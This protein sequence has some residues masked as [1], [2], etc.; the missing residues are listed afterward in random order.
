VKNVLVSGGTRGLGLAVARTLAT[1]HYHVIACGRRMSQ[2]LEALIN[3]QGLSGR[4][5]FAAVDLGETVGIHGFVRRI[6]EEHGELYGLVNN[7]AIGQE[8]ILATMHESEI[9]DLIRVNVTG[10]ILLTKYASRSMLIRR[11]GRIVNIAS[12]VGHTGFNGLS[13][14]A[15]T[16]G[17]LLGFT[18]SLAR[19]LGKA[20]VTVNSVSPGFLETEMTESVGDKNL[21][22]IRRRSPLG[23][24]AQVNDVAATVA[25]LLSESAGSMTGTDLVVDAG[26]IA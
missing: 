8:G 5:S 26:S 2:G 14:Y 24:L 12:V 18:K 11:S 7:A 15:A 21:D 6:I 17:A 13:V 1:E 23:R 3:E 20:D 19:E 4:V 9:D 16:K 25:F 10:T 22:R